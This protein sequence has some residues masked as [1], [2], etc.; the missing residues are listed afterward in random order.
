MG[1]DFQSGAEAETT[2]AQEPIPG[3]EFWGLIWGHGRKKVTGNAAKKWAPE[4]GGL[5]N[6][7]WAQFCKYVKK[8]L[9]FKFCS[10]F[11]SCFWS[12]Q[13]QVSI[14]SRCAWHPK[15]WCCNRGCEYMLD[16][17]KCGKCSSYVT[18]KMT[19]HSWMIF[20]KSLLSHHHHNHPYIDS[21]IDSIHK[22]VFHCRLITIVTWIC[23]P[24]TMVHYWFINALNSDHP[25]LT[26]IKHDWHFVSS[27][28]C[29]ISVF[30]RD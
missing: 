8:L 28:P 1:E 27:C 10:F 2:S 19:W 14:L 23:H 16:Q 12:V 5:W 30:G 29:M 15:K 21:L 9:T 18:W 7:K 3:T 25:S 11:S 26:M 13:L 6:C 22:V 17:D 24:S 4:I 20:D